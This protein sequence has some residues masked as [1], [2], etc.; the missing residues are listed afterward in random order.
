MIFSFSQI[1]ES[2]RTGFF[3]LGERES[4][5]VSN[6]QLQE[7]LKQHKLDIDSLHTQI[8]AHENDKTKLNKTISELN[9]KLFISDTTIDSLQ[10]QIHQMNQSESLSRARA[11][12]ESI[13]ST[14]RQKHENEILTLNEKLDD[15]K[16]A[17]AWKVSF[18]YNCNIKASS[19]KL[20]K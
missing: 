2:T 3:D 9:E 16:Q 4:F 17:L 7:L 6:G 8:E 11:Q 13:L 1:A 20:L 14:M 12:H 19:R 15:I 5:Q 18:V 10:Q